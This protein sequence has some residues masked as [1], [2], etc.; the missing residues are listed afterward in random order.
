MDT[1][2]NKYYFLIYSLRKYLIEVY[3]IIVIKVKLFNV[4]YF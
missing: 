3:A 2:L 4:T 1:K